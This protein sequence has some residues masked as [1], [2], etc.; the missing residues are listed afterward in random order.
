MNTPALEVI[1][2]SKSFGGTR[3]LREVSFD[4]ARGSILGL[5]G[6]NGS[7]KSTL[8]KIL[9]G[10]HEPDPGGV[11]RVGGS[12]V[13][14]P[15]APGQS[16]RVGLSF[17]HQDLGLIPRLTVLENL[18]VGR[19][20]TGPGWR[21]RWGQERASVRRALDRFE[22]ALSPDS[23]VAD[24]APVDRALIAIVRAFSDVEAHAGGVLVLDEPTA[25]LPRDGVGRLFAAI[26]RVAAAGTS[27][28]FVSHQLEEI[29]GL[30]DQVAV[31]RNGDLL[32]VLPTAEVSEARLIEMILGQ[33]LD[34]SYPQPS[35]HTGE[36]LLSVDALS[37]RVAREVSFQVRRGEVLGLAGLVG[38]GH[39]EVPYLL[40]G[41]ARAAAG[42]LRMGALDAPVA[43]MSPRRAM[44]AGMALLPADRQHAGGVGAL[45]VK[46]NVTLPILGT[47]AHAGLLRHQVESAHA[48]GLLRAY[49]VRP[50]APARRLETLSGGNQ[51]KALLGKWLQRSPPL[52]LL[53]EPTQ[54]VDVG[55]R[56]EIFTHISNAAAGGSAVIMCGSEYGDLAHTCDRVLVFRYG[57][58]VAE[59]AGVNL[60]EER[61][62][63]QCYASGEGVYTTF[64]S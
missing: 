40:F 18:R 39:E 15:L 12:E 33:R 46:H 49:D 11:L 34:E 38:M 44:A 51:Q 48:L 28:I 59:L 26:R 5:V 37:G 32:A 22:L 60:T 35:S 23:L 25:Y 4:L 24:L 55:A 41:A 10:Y 16:H 8:I 56:K 52:L 14:F 53:H 7:G 50:P 58:L 1:R 29:R 62:V 47:F 30:T 2:L 21:I 9:S 54:G 57:R 20:H 45:S 61:I 13:T 64:L 63:E 19:F 43:R 6:R 17:V 31:L 3:V 36:V 27:V 42:R